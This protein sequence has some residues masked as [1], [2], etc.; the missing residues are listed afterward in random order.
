MCVGD[1]R[2]DP[3][4]EVAVCGQD[5]RGGAG[6]VPVAGPGQGGSAELP[7]VSWGDREGDQQAP[8]EF[9]L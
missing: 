3:D 1:H 7:E 9:G 6:C 4:F 8:E 5:Y 2:G